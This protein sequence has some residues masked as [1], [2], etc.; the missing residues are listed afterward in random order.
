MR[1]DVMPF[2]CFEMNETRV[3]SMRDVPTSAHKVAHCNK[4]KRAKLCRASPWSPSDFFFSFE[5]Q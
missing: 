4:T 1:S 2:F 5:F 3:T